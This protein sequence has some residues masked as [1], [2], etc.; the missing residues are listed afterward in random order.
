M[1][2]LSLKAL[3]RIEFLCEY[4][5]E[6]CQRKISYTDFSVHKNSCGYGP[7]QE[8]SDLKA[9][10]QD[11]QAEITSLKTSIASLEGS[12]EDESRVHERTTEALKL[13]FKTSI[14]SWEGRLEDERRVHERTTEALKVQFRTSITSLE[15][16]LEDER[17]QYELT[18]EALT[19]QFYTC[20]KTE[21]QNTAK[22][23]LQFHLHRLSFESLKKNSIY[24]KLTL[25]LSLAIL[26]ILT[27][28]WYSDFFHWYFFRFL[29]HFLSMSYLCVCVIILTDS[30]LF[31]Y[32]L[33]CL[34][35]SVLTLLFI[36]T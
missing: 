12:L 30:S 1:S 10:V 36:I 20:L 16:S 6:G 23:E 28:V 32:K 15:G 31:R 19:V 5:V 25:Y 13:Q 29:S 3:K 14:T 34:L 11:C 27:I 26:L 21:R 17:R 2:A 8:I 9:K 33:I 22:A 18:T 35:I 7:Y 4:H 24:M